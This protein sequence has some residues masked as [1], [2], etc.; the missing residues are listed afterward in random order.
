LKNI[1]QKDKQDLAKKL[2]RQMEDFENDL[3][4]NG[5]TQRTRNKANLIQHQLMKL[6]N[7]ALKQGE[8]K[9]RESK[10]NSNQ[11]QNPILTKPS[12][13]KNKTNTIEILNRQALPLRQNYKHSDK[14]EISG[15]IFISIERVMENASD[16]NVDF[17]EELKRVMSHGVLHLLGYNDKTKEDKQVMR[18]KENEMIQLFHVEQ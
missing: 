7:A 3:L 5:I 17:E 11:F 9:E 4:E 14:N 16:Y 6:E 12:L 2:V 13:L 15:D 1:L 18:S 8:K 10:T